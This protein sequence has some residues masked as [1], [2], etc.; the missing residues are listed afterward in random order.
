MPEELIQ[1]DGHSVQFQRS[2]HGPAAVLVHGLLG[3]SFSWRFA[4]P[5]LAKAR[6]VF[7]LDMPGSGLSE[8]D[9]HLDCRLK[10]AAQ[11]LL[12][13]LDTVGV[14]YCDLIG[15]SYGG[16]T[17][18]MAAA[19]QPSRIRTLTIVSPANP[20]SRVGRMR[21]A[22]LR[23]PMLA[24][25]FPTMARQMSWLNVHFLRRMYG[26]PAAVT[27]ETIRGYGVPLARRGV[28]EHAVAIVASWDSDMRELEAALPKIAD[29]PVLILWGS[30][31]RV[32]DP[33]SAHRLAERLPKAEIAVIEGVGHLPYEENPEQF[34]RIVLSFLEKYSEPAVAR[35][36]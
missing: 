10:C 31:D 7:A 15:S 28:L 12:E 23:N 36:K 21:L 17:A 3:Y 29:T 6:E 22:L 33:T 13:F 16:T 25:A 11:R 20:W 27:T 8:C 4:V 5:L 9:S 2:G 1:V 14:D 34:S 19:L 24:A 35:G 30:T 32:V 26:D 18:M